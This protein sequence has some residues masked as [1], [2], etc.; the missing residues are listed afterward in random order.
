MESTRANWRSRW[1][2]ATLFTLL[3]VVDGILF[4][5]NRTLPWFATSVWT[6]CSA[7]V[8]AWLSTWPKERIVED[9]HPIWSK[10]GSKARPESYAHFQHPQFPG[11]S[12]WGWG[13]CLPSLHTNRGP[14][15][16]E[17]ISLGASM[18]EWYTQVRQL[19]SA[20]AGAYSSLTGQT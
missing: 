3:H 2:L 20:G 7:I 12:F 15:S 19:A 14:I 11:R 16:P 8:S 1:S 4:L 17:Q 9:T 6:V 18:C 10:E 5:L 13:D